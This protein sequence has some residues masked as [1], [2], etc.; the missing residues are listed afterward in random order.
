M[1]SGHTPAATLSCIHARQCRNS[2]EKLVMGG[3]WMWPK[4]MSGF[5]LGNP[6]FLGWQQH[7]E[8][9]GQILIKI[10]LQYCFSVPAFSTCAP[11]LSSKVDDLLSF[12]ACKRCMS[13]YAKKSHTLFSVCL[14]STNCGAN[15]WTDDLLICCSIN[16]FVCKMF[17]SLNCQ[18]KVQRYL[19]FW[20]EQGPGMTS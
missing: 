19:F 3:I 13:P 2:W 14:Y 6:S 8:T 15:D 9:C 10:E 18:A 4:V 20:R 7:D 12:V 11:T 1:L 5:L 17:K 16:C